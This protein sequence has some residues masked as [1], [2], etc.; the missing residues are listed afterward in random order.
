MTTQA[1]IKKKGRS[2]VHDASCIRTHDPTVRVYTPQTAR[3][4]CHTLNSLSCIWHPCWTTRYQM[5]RLKDIC[6]G[7]GKLVPVF[8]SLRSEDV[9]GSGCIDQH[10]FDLGISWRW[11]VR[12]TTRPLYQEKEPPSTHWIGGW[13]DPKSS[14]DDM[15]K[16]KFLASLKSQCCAVPWYSSAGF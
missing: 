12:F 3:P 8:N 1:W 9:W 16:W 13:V 2:F 15:E 6:I 11:V 7:K 4:F 14:L 10:F 5:Q